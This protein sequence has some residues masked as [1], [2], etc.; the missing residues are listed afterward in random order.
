MRSTL[1]VLTQLATQYPIRPSIETDL[2]MLL[3][4]YPSSCHYV[5]P[6]R[7]SCLPSS[8][9]SATK[10]SS[11]NTLGLHFIQTPEASRR[12]RLLLEACISRALP[13]Q[14][15]LP[16]HSPHYFCQARSLP[17]T[18]RRA[19]QG[20][21]LFDISFFSS[22]IRNFMS[23]PEPLEE[24]PVAREQKARKEA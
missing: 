4:S 20:L 3:P 17:T 5:E 10:P 18:N 12:V 8:T 6:L 2:N 1:A 21:V 13:A 15:S 7:H 14:Q 19:F 23:W 24:L 22:I 16:L 11:S 9:S